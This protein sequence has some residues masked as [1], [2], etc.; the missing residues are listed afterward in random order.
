[1]RAGFS[2]IRV[3]RAPAGGPS[4][5]ALATAAGYGDERW[6]VECVAGRLLPG[7]KEV[8]LTWH[9]LENVEAPISKLDPRPHN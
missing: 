1:M 4:S 9:P 5:T 6:R 3:H 8:P 2:G 7:C